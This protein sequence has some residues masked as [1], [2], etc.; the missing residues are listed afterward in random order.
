MRPAGSLATR[1]ASAGR[2]A[3]RIVAALAI[4]QTVGYGILYYAFAV[5]LNPVAAD[6]HTST[7][8]VTGTFTASVLT[9][10]VLAVP[11]GRWLDRHGG[12]ALMTAG[13]LASCPS[14]VASPPPRCSGASVRRPWSPSC[15]RSKALPRPRSRSS[16]VTPSR[17]SSE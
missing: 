10:A 2:H 16:V 15:S 12:R 1:P 8:A 4:M 17:R 9:S 6:L 11:V 13:S 3:R 7:T 5:F 14:P